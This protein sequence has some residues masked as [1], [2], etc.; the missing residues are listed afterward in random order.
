MIVIKYSSDF[1][2]EKY[3]K[4][5]LVSVR[6]NVHDSD[7]TKIFLSKAQIKFL[8]LVISN[9]KKKKKES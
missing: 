6:L 1:K 2:I 5:C 8:N 3:K 9:F 7:Y 4:G